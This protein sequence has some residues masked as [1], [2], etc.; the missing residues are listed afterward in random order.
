MNISTR[1][2][3][4][5]S[6]LVVITLACS[7]VG[8]WNIERLSES[9]HYVTGPAWNAADGAMEGTIGVEAELIAVN[10]I[11]NQTGELSVAEA[12]L[13]D[14][15]NMA[16]DAFQRMR[17]SGL[18]DEQRLLLFDTASASFDTAQEE[19]LMSFKAF[20]SLDRRLDENFNRFQT[21]MT[22][23]EEVGDGSVEALQQNPDL[24]LSWNSGL[25]EKWTAA[26]GAM[27]SQIGMLQRVYHYERLTAGLVDDTV[28]AELDNSL[29]FLRNSLAEVVDHPLFTGS[30]VSPGSPFTGKSYAQALSD[31][32]AIH[33]ADFVEAV[34]A[35]RKFAD[36]NKAYE[37]QA[38]A[39]LNV[40]EDLEEIGDATIEGQIA[41]VSETVENAQKTLLLAV[42]LGV[43]IA[44][45]GAFWIIQ[46]IRQ[47]LNQAV[48]LA[49]AVSLG[50]LSQ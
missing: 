29:D 11:I 45:P 39:F 18:I 9:L 38:V 41:A 44:L 28:L 26:D 13:S 16:R 23:A 19:L 48:K 49:K 34:E 27:E 10:A 25:Q 24:L 3:G 42:V 35:Y 21:L 17:E 32:L 47:P 2:V 7:A 30:G 22:E 46:S 8:Y 43:L 15:G 12:M 6:L 50:D 4:G 14:A 31:A 37:L 40:V 36:A 5:F 20:A 33:I 1:I